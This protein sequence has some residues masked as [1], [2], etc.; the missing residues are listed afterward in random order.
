MTPFW[1]WMV[2]ITAAVIATLVTIG[3]AAGFNGGFDFSLAEV[4]RAA[5]ASLLMSTVVGG[6]SYMFAASFCPAAPTVTPDIEA[7]NEKGTER[8][9]LVPPMPA[10]TSGPNA[11]P[12]NPTQ[13]Q[14]HY[15]TLYLQ[16]RNKD[17]KGESVKGELQSIVTGDNAAAAPGVRPG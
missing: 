13:E 12:P 4:I 16:Y 9:S 11:S 2:V 7:N 10:P 6:V 3:V 17:E 5:Y 1:R 15:G 14:T 8:S